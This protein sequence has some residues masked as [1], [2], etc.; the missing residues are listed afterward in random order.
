MEPYAPMRLVV[1]SSEFP[2]MR[3]SGAVQMRDLVRELESHG[4]EVTCLVPSFLAEVTG[5]N[6]EI[7]G[8]VQRPRVPNQKHPKKLYRA[9]AEVL[10]PLITMIFV[11]VRR[12]R[13]A[14]AEGV[15]WYSPSI[16][17]GPTIWLLRKLGSGPGYL[18]IR[19]IFPEW[20]LDT[21]LIRRGMIYRFFHYVAAFQ[22]AQASVIGIQT[23]GNRVYFEELERQG[24]RIEVLDNWLGDA[25]AGNC[26]IQLSTTTLAGKK[27][28]VYAGNM[29]LA[30]GMD[31]IVDLASHLIERTDIGF[32]LVGRGTE[33]VRLRRIAAE[34]E[35][36]NILFFD[37][38]D[39]DEIAGL[40]AQCHYGLIALDSQ[41]RTHNIPGKFLTYMAAGLPVLAKVNIGNDLVDLILSARVGTV[42][43]DSSTESLLLA[44]H[45]LI[46]QVEADDAY[47]TRCR[48][49]SVERFSARRAAQQIVAAL[50]NI[51]SKAHH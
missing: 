1:V 36:T 8:P 31:A 47:P 24:R 40:Y 25:P 23:P 45:A 22:Y 29:G 5:A 35:L 12:E 41:H 16:F 6:G 17:H 15:I 43:T 3:S 4:H 9:L 13:F 30:Q 2:P 49:L 50:H 38:I 46:E 19:D 26:S 21:G 14:D 44:A 34:L 51:K 18:I 39:P 11:M 48:A 20:A 28:F 33:Q 7:A 37:E 10:M 32:V 27:I 42:C